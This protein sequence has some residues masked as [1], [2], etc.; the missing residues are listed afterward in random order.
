MSGSYEIDGVTITPCGGGYYDL[1]HPSIPDPIRERGKDDAEARAKTLAAE[2]SA[3][4]SLPGQSLDDLK[5]PETAAPGVDEEVAKL[6]V[7]LAEAEAA[8]AQAE[9]EKVEALSQ[10]KT[11]T[12]VM[13]G[14]APAEPARVPAGVPRKFDGVLDDKAKARLK[15]LGVETTTIILEEN[16]AI[17]PTGLFV[18]HNG[19]GYMIVPGEKVDVPNFLLGVLDD[20]VQASPVVDS[21]SQ[22]VL[23]Y[24]NRMRYPYRKLG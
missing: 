18:G 5:L 22:K 13:T 21:K 23:G 24:R 10:L 8:R 2:L 15:E 9:K 4:A 14:E 7:Q 11:R 6:R 1:S 17:P 16:E 12:V 20:A 3:N 19:R